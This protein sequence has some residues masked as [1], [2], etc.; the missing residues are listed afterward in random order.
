MSCKLKHESNFLPFTNL[1]ALAPANKRQR[2]EDKGA[3]DKGVAGAAT[4]SVEQDMHDEGGGLRGVIV[5]II[6]AMGLMGTCLPCKHLL[7]I[8]LLNTAP[9]V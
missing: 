6:C 9:D 2:L 8:A 4:H 1:V 7:F 3:A 5:W